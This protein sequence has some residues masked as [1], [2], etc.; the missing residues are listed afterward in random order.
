[1]VQFTSVIE[2]GREELPNN[3]SR[4]ITGITLA[5]PEGTPV[6]AYGARECNAPEP[7]QRA[8]RL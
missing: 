5:L 6:L 7:R 1:M 2:Q 3:A 8:S 4:T